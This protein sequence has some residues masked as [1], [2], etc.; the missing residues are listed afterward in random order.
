MSFLTKESIPRKS[1]RGK[2]MRKFDQLSRKHLS[3][4]IAMS[5]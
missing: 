2:D 3:D 4:L 1:K 5:F